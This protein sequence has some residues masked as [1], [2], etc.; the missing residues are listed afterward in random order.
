LH[1]AQTRLHD[2]LLE[3]VLY[4]DA[5]KNR[6]KELLLRKAQMDKEVAEIEG[7]WLDGQ[8]ALEALAREE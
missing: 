8:E 4:E 2:E 7:E 6:L 3:P 5:N 1:A